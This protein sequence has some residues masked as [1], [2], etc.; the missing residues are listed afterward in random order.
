[1][2]T[3]LF[4][5]LLVATLSKTTKFL[6]TSNEGS[7]ITFTV[8]E[9]NTCQITRYQAKP[10]SIIPGDSIEFKMQISALQNVNIKELYLDTLNNGVSLFTDHVAVS[11]NYATGEKDIV[12]YTAAIPSFCPSGSWDIYLYLIDEDGNKAATLL[13]HFDV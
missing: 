11:K 4:V 12:G 6:G 1:M 3:T 7:P 5:I 9:E 10:D 13:A 8:V 2:R